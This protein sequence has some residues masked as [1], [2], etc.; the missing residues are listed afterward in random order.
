MYCNTGVIYVLKNHKCVLRRKSYKSPCAHSSEESLQLLNWGAC[1]SSAEQTALLRD[2][3]KLT[4]DLPPLHMKTGITVL[5]SIISCL[6]EL[7]K[8]KKLK[9][10]L[11]V[12]TM[13]M[14]TM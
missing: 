14:K 9:M 1:L 7:H 4:E 3:S 13:N 11:M 5:T 8:L 6:L 12:N 10:D 2:F